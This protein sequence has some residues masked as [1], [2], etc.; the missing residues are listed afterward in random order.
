MKQCTNYTVL[1]G[2]GIVAV[3]LQILVSV[4]WFSNDSGNQ[5]AIRLCDDQGV[6][7]GQRTICFGVLSKELY[8][9]IYGVDVIEKFFFVSI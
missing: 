2:Y 6:Q 3:P 7:K 5:A 1:R 4:N 8:A 9:F